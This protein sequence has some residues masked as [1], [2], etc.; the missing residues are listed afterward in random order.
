MKIQRFED[1]ECWQESRVLVNMVYKVVNNARF[2][3]DY[4]LVNQITGAVI[5][6][7]NNIC[8]GFD[9]QSNTEFIRFLRYSRRS[10]SEVQNCT[11]VAI[12]QNYVSEEERMEIYDQ[13]IKVRKIIDG[14]IRYLRG[15]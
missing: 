8:E 5:S 14:L 9:S 12:D 7:M 15:K 6:I 13:C 3:R 1:L 2:Q 11:Y 10:A 4:R